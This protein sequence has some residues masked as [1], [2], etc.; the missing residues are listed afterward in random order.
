MIPNIKNE[1]ESLYDGKATVYDFAYVDNGHGA[2]VLS[3]TPTKVYED[4]P[5]RLSYENIEANTQDH[6]GDLVQEIV[7]FCDPSYKI[8]PGA[9]ITIEQAGGTF[10]YQCAGLRAM[11]FSHQEIKL[12][13]YRERA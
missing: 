9:K 10:T 3:G 1:L 7:L 11:Y 4:I 2:K 6:Y 12:T 13:A 8:N 5:C